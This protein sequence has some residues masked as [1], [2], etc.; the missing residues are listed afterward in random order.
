MTRTC[1]YR[2]VSSVC[3]T[4]SSIGSSWCPPAGLTLHARVVVSAEQPTHALVRVRVELAVDKDDF[5]S[6][7]EVLPS[8]VVGEDNCA[9]RPT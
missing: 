2:V 7:R 3:T 5:G 6:A 4:T 8:V 1:T 9:S